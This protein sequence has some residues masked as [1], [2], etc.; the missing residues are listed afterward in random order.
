MNQ[1][2]TEAFIDMCE[3]L[4]IPAEEGLFEKTKISV[5]QAK[6]VKSESEIKSN[7]YR[8]E[9][10]L[11]LTGPNKHQL[12]NIFKKMKSKGTWGYIA[13]G[14]SIANG[15]GNTAYLQSKDVSGQGDAV[16]YNIVEFDGETYLIHRKYEL[17]K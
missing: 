9:P 6:D 3:D 1:I 4:M 12:K 14:I 2:T 17:N 13:A 15:Y 10:L 8:E 5:K 16:K 11:H 7:M